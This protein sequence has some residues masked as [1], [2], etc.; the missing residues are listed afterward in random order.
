[1]GLLD[2]IAGSVLNQAGTADTDSPTGMLE[3]IMNLINQHEGGLAGLI[4]TFQRGGLGE[5]VSSWV[6]R[7]DNLPVS[8]EQ[9]Q[10]VLGHEQVS[11]IA[12]KLGID[13]AAAAAGLA[14]LLPQVIDKLTPEGSVEG[15]SLLA[16]AAIG[17]LKG[18]L[19]G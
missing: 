18:K 17:A 19:F 11:A 15:S 1:M 9:I 7:G 12:T 16:N 2:Q 4:S 14:Q 3:I 10:A 6:S 8:A 13:P 5:I